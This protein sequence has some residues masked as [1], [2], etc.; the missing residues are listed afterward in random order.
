VP[1]AVQADVAVEVAL[2]LLLLVLGHSVEFLVEPYE[3][4]GIRRTIDS[5]T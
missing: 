1:L 5:T 2:F 4:L 3:P